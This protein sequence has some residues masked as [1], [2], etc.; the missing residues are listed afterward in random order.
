[1]KEKRSQR[2]EQEEKLYKYV[3][4]LLSEQ[5]KKDFEVTIESSPALQKEARLIKNLT[6]VVQ[7]PNW[8]KTAGTLMELKQQKLGKVPDTTA[9][10]KSILSQIR[11]FITGHKLL[12]FFILLVLAIIFLLTSNLFILADCEQL[13]KKYLVRYDNIVTPNPAARPELVTAIEAYEKGR[14]D[15]AY[16]TEAYANF[17]QIR[18]K[19]PLFR[20]YTAVSGMLKSEVEINRI[21]EEFDALRSEIEDDEDKLYEHFLDWMD[22]YQ[23]LLD[24]KGKALQE[25]KDGIS[26]LSERPELDLELRFQVDRLQKQLRYLYMA[27]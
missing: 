7:D 8:A 22:Y 10:N 18:E 25:G 4:G 6:E 14:E 5:E 16:Y 19:D 12:V 1:M 23:V 21:Q 15:S 17:Y 11:K 2:L 3:N 13:Y 9:T 20:F 24:I 26:A 27:K